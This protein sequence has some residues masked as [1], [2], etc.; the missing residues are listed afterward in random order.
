MGSAAD[1]DRVFTV[2]FFMPRF[3]GQEENP[4]PIFWVYHLASG[5]SY[6]SQ[7]RSGLNVEIQVKRATISVFPSHSKH[8]LA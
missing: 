6:L 7:L 3:G 1:T 4:S 8:V 5:L 2:P